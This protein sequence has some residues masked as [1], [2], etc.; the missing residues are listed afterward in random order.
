MS[1]PMV[2]RVSSHKRLA[3]VDRELVS[4]FKDAEERDRVKWQE[5]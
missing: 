2:P 4:S 3:F 1:L 5:D